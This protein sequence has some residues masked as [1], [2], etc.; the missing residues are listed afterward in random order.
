MESM[1]RRQREQLQQRGRL[2]LP[3]CLFRDHVPV[4]VHPE[5]AEELDPHLLHRARADRSGRR[6]MANL[7]PP[8]TRVF[9]RLFAPGRIGTLELANRVIKSPLATGMAHVDGTVSERLLRHYASI[10]AG[11]ASLVM[12]EY[13]YVDEIASKAAH[14]QLGISTDEHIAGLAHL[15]DVIHWNGAKAGCQIVHAGCQRPLGRGPIKAPSRFAGPS[16]SGTSD[17]LPDELTVDEIVEIVAAFG[18]AAWRAVRA[19]FDLV[20]IH[21]AHGYLIT[22]FLSPHT[23]A[24]D[25][26]YGGEFDNRARFLVEVTEQ[27]RASLPPAFPLTVRLN[28]SDYEPD[29]I[30]VDEAVETARIAE[31]AGV[32][33]VHVSGGDHRTVAHMVAPQLLPHGQNVPAAAAVKR[34]IG[35]PVIVVGSLIAPDDAEQVLADGNADFVALGRALLADPE[36]P[37]KA[38]SGRADEIRPCIRCN[39]GCLA[40]TMLNFRAITCSVNPCVGLE[41]E[42]PAGPAAR[43]RRVAVVGGGVAGLEAARTAAERGHAVTL[44]ERSRLGGQLAAAA[45]RELKADLRSYLAWLIRTVE[46]AEI[47]IA[48]REPT[49]PELTAFDAVV[50]ATGSRPRA[51]GENPLEGSEG[52]RR[53][54]VVGGGGTGV[55]AAIQAAEDGARVTLVEMEPVL[56]ANETFTDRTTFAERL[57]GVG[58]DVRTSSCALRVDTDGVSIAGPTGTETLA[59]DSVIVAVGVE[60]RHE[61]AD[62]LRGLVETYVIGD[63]LRPGRI[64]DAVHSAQQAV[65]AL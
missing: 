7:P 47:E 8:A 23:N 22:N 24:R 58:V 54:V 37:A 33:A 64:H 51:L 11:G 45:E 31:R 30:T 20:E 48:P 13:A 18:A 52:A 28:G 40:R 60:P 19:G 4:E 57:R 42:L 26:A 15:V 1:S 49:L 44:F 9:P 41:G 39:D 36:W 59:A 10:A 6:I 34:A 55:E 3:P 62:E 2:A 16:F 17:K 61:L 29:G 12:V 14:G 53:V 50:V 21:G 56:M 38:A 43:S 63:A 35:V 65:V 25:D 46:R 32:D 27:V 5:A